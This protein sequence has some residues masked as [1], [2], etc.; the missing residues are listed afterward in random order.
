MK[1]EKRM[2]DLYSTLCLHGLWWIGLIE[3]GNMEGEDGV[4]RFCY[5]CI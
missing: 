2:M 4:N 5:C 3:M 1:E